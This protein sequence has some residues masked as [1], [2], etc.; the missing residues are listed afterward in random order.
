MQYTC[1]GS[2][3]NRRYVVTAAHCFEDKKRTFAE[4]VIG[5]HDLATNP[6][7]DQDANGKLRCEN[8][9]VQR[10]QMIQDDVIIHEGWNIRKLKEEA[11]DIVLIRLPRLVYT[12]NEIPSGVHVS[13]VCLPWGALPNGKIARY[14]SGEISLAN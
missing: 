14:P 11:N 2:L 4:V 8:K 12:M 3:I 10:F 6:E 5:D 13:P 7:C 1:G 9:P